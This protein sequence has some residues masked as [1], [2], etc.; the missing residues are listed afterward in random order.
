MYL[1]PNTKGF[2]LLELLVGI[3][4]MAILLVG[5][6]TVVPKLAGFSRSTGERWAARSQNA[7]AI[8]HIQQVG[9][10]AQSCSKIDT[11]HLQ[12]RINFAPNASKNLQDVRFRFDSAAEKIR[13]ER[14]DGANW[15]QLLEYINVAKFV[16]CDLSAMSGGNCSI[17]PPSL[18]VLAV[19]HSASGGRFF[20]V[21]ISGRVPAETPDAL[22]P[23]LQTAFFVRHP[24][25][26]P[27]DL[28][29]AWGASE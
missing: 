21:A 28:E 10:L 19:N 27:N 11:D 22:A 18:N 4:A 9:R 29:F 7:Q 25:G 8:L 17:T 3:A 26:L 23:V 24:T 6:I 14:K 1:L 13:Y 5:A 15:N 12:C 16:V 20:R 2:S